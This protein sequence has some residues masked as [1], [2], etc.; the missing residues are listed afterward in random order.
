VDIA[1]S[2]SRPGV[3]HAGNFDGFP[4]GSSVE[5][6]LA[7]AAIVASDA[8]L[9]NPGY[10]DGTSIVLV[11]PE[12]GSVERALRALID[13]PQRIGA[14]ARAGQAF[15]RERY[16]PER[17]IAPRWALLSKLMQPAA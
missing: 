11:E 9:Q 1:V 7:G 4:T 17:Q 6:S 2:L 8:L 14:I 13:A 5:A 12:A 15:T 10:R 3:L 16:A